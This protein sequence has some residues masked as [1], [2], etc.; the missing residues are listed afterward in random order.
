MDK[1]A[2]EVP[3]PLALEFVGWGGISLGKLE[4]VIFGGI[5]PNDVNN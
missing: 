4:D 5:K 3:A 1:Y 2:Q